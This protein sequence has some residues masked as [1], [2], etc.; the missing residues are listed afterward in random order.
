MDFDSNKKTYFLE[1]AD[2]FSEE[3]S[4]IK[5]PVNRNDYVNSE[6]NK[7]PFCTYYYEALLLCSGSKILLDEALIKSIN[8]L[9][10][11]C[12]IINE[13]NFLEIK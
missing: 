10:N 5:F 13:S 9:S 1:I 11:A 2:V 7:L 6:E 8:L 12:I 4:F 3:E